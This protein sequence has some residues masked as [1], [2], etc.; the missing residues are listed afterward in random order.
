MYFLKNYRISHLIT[1]KIEDKN[2]LFK[3]NLKVG[4]YVAHVFHLIFFNLTILKK[5]HAIKLNLGS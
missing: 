3:K 1:N 5:N 4:I 2:K